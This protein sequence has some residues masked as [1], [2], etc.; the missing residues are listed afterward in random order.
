MAKNKRKKNKKEVKSDLK[1]I[2]YIFIGFILFLFLLALISF[3][4]FDEKVFFPLVFAAIFIFFMCIGFFFFKKTSKLLLIYNSII[5]S[6]SIIEDKAVSS[7]D[8][9]KIKNSF[10]NK[11]IVYHLVLVFIGLIGVFFSKEVNS[12]D[13]GSFISGYLDDILFQFSSSMLFI[14]I[15]IFNPFLDFSEQFVLFIKEKNKFLYN[16]ISDKKRFFKI[17]LILCIAIV[18]FFIYNDYLVF[19]SFFFN[20]IFIVSIS[21]TLV[22]Y[23]IRNIYMMIKFPI[24][25]FNENMLRMLKLIFNFK[26]LA[27]VLIPLFVLIMFGSKFLGFENEQ[28]DSSIFFFIGFNCFMAYLEYSLHRN[29][30]KNTN[31]TQI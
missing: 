20:D 7:E 5:E 4:F 26:G 30:I 27:F 14:I 1:T 29:N 12:T 6:T 13:N 22:F 3:S 15:G 18:A 8:S 10:L 19:P 24:S 28:F 11:P 17:R 9:E 31:R 16:I 23:I 2:K 21:S 25:F